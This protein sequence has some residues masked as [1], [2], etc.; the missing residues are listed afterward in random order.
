MNI[1]VIVYRFSDHFAD[2]EEGANSKLAISSIVDRD[3]TV[4][5]THGFNGGIWDNDTGE[6]IN[7]Y[8]IPDVD[9]S[10]FKETRYYIILGKDVDYTLQGYKTGGY[11]PEDKAESPTATITR[12]ETTLLLILQ[13]IL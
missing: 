2:F 13:E 6:Q 10:S 3:K 12:E 4:I 8:S 1:P 7:S 11:D 9:E 5:L